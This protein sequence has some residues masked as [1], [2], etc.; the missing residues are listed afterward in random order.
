M[1]VLSSK[2][3]LELLK[4]TLGIGIVIL[5]IEAE[6]PRSIGILLLDIYSIH[7]VSHFPI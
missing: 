1:L 5:I 2:G 3:V 4:R 6:I 7:K